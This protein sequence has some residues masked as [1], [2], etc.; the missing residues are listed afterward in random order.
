MEIIWNSM[1]WRLMSQP[2]G[3]KHFGSRSWKMRMKLKDEKFQ[4][5]LA[6][7]VIPDADG[8][9]TGNFKLSGEVAPWVGASNKSRSTR[10]AFF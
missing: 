3:G 7:H 10:D 8:N 9:I 1:S 6:W 5:G 2:S 4:N